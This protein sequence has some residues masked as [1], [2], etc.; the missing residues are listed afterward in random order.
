MRLGVDEVSFGSL[1]LHD[2]VGAKGQRRAACES[3]FVGD[4]RGGHLS[5]GER[6]RAVGRDDV[7]RGAHLVGGVG[8]G[9]FASGIG[10]A[11]LDDACRLAVGSVEGDGDASGL[12]VAVGEANE[13]G[14]AGAHVAVGC[15]RLDDHVG[16]QMK[17]LGHRRS[18][19]VRFQ[20]RHRLARLG[21]HGS[22][23]RH[24]VLDGAHFPNDARLGD[25][26]A[27]VGIDL[28][29][30][31]APCLREVFHDHFDD[32]LLVSVG[33]GERR[34]LVVQHVAGRRAG[35]LHVVR[36]AAVELVGQRADAL[37]VG[38]ELADDGASR[39]HLEGEGLFALVEDAEGHAPVHAP[40]RL[41][42]LLD[43]AHDGARLVL[44]RVGVRAPV[45][46]HGGAELRDRFV[47]CGRRGG[48]L[49]HEVGAEGQRA[50]L[51]VFAQACGRGEAVL[52]RDD[53]GDALPGFGVEDV[54][55]HA[56]E[57]TLDALVA[58]GALA[59]AHF[60]HGDVAAD[61]ALG[62]GGL[63]EQRGERARSL[64]RHGQGDGGGVGQKIAFG[65]LR[66]AHH[67]GA[68]RKPRAR[69]VRRQRRGVEARPS[70]FVRDDGG[71][72]RGGEPRRGGLF[73][74]AERACVMFDGEHGPGQRRASLRGRLPGF[75]VFL[76]CDDVHGP[77]LGLV[78]CIHPHGH[79]LAAVL[80]G[81]AHGVDLPVEGV[82][83]GWLDLLDPVLAR[84]KRRFAGSASVLS[85]DDAL[86]LALACGVGVH[87][88]H[89]PGQRVAGV[90]VCDV[91]H[92]GRLGH[93]DAAEKRGLS[94]GGPR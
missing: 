77:Q 17:A 69:R 24:D 83:G 56:G 89:G 73:G 68:E 78:G 84:P 34:R 55:G 91:G 79:V 35:F 52:V 50:D 57:R 72:E 82:A 81:E 15:A 18:V 16:T 5:C 43:D 3:L 23:S 12:G 94:A 30:L 70:V 61:D 44:H 86:H 60:E 74:R 80:H 40:P 32:A 1:R 49:P 62:Y 54:E 65:R 42:V 75:G 28:A 39:A 38:G 4:E 41:G 46:G 47:A 11:D 93:L 64:G 21:A 33:Q 76:G 88:V 48:V 22:V 14:L 87:A 59:V 13:C 26:R 29:H 25:G 63:V 8:D 45:F 90:A 36:A 10:L 6:R 66:L 2:L 31:D 53:A 71:R 9:P 27:R 85:G 58:H 92:R 51:A 20:Q 37:F 19:V 7:V 67:D